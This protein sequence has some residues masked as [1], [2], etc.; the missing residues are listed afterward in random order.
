MADNSTANKRLAKNSIFLSI[1]M[2]FVLC[3]TLYTTRAVLHML[4]VEDYGVYNVVCGFVSMFTFLSTS[5]SNGI[6]RFF[7][8]E[9]GKNG[10]EGAC[11]VFNTSL[12]IQIAL[13]VL[14][15]I[16]LESL[17]L[18]YI[19]NKMVIPE[20]RMV[21]AQWIFQFSIFSFAFVIIQAPYLAAV[22]AHE[23]M[24]F[25]AI[26]SVLD[27]IFKLG[28]VFIIPCLHGDNLILYG[29]LVAFISVFNFLC[30]FLYSKNK[31]QEIEIKHIFDKKLFNNM[32]G[33]SGWNVFGSLSGVMKEQ[34]IN[35]VINLFFGPVVNA[36]RGVAAQVNNGLQG[37]VTTITTPVRPQVVQSY[38]CGDYV[39]TMNLTFSI[40]K[41]SCVVLYIMALPVICEIDYILSL[42]L[43]DNV[44][45]HAN[46]FIVI[47]IL[48]SF[49][50]NLNSAVSGVIHASGRM[51]N[52]QLITSFISILCIPGAY[53]SL[54]MGASPEIALFMV[55]LFSAL[56]QYSALLILKSIIN[57]KLSIY[58]NNVLLPL[59]WFVICTSPI[60][61]LF[62]LLLEESLLRLVI[63]VSISILISLISLYYIVLN[64][65]EK[66]LLLQMLHNFK[67]K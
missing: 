16:I 67:K 1:R 56:S 31:F 20:N 13:T 22:M 64:R 52:Y 9:L 26:V 61:I 28:I 17:G 43:G 44:P 55:F 23:R 46:M 38:A 53:I 33:F 62:R 14:I 35:L 49:V 51:R 7:N 11:R 59:F 29:L 2:V 32:L 21:A 60:P 48:V 45:E 5:L 25:F 37:F 3:I 6:Q 65:S 50:N 42:W 40:S 19:S 58:L 4:G 8:Y 24:D 41:L 27:A 57:Y 36:A 12:I 18:W 66:Q 10:I 63:V 34:G 54:K 47:V 15:I 30:Y 39:R